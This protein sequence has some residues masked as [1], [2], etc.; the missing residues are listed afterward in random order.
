MTD[1]PHNI[2]DRFY[3][4]LAGKTPIDE[5]E[6]WVYNSTELEE[7]LGSDEYMDFILFDYKQKGARYEIEHL[8]YK[9]IDK[10]EFEAWKVKILLFDALNRTGDYTLAIRLFY[11]LYCHGYGFMENLG[12]GYGLTLDCPNS[13]YGVDNFEE[14]TNEQKNQLV[15]SFYPEI[16]AEINKV[17][18]V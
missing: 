1:T 15:N 12:L 2:K 10:S 3:K 6:S 16:Q 4:I 14:L 13:S 17:L 9:H 18:S 8:I 7:Y 5:F 11:D